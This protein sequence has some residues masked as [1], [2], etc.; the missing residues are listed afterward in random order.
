MIGNRDIELIQTN[1]WNSPHSKTNPKGYYVTPNYQNV[2]DK[3]YALEKRILDLISLIEIIYEWNQ[4]K[5]DYFISGQKMNNDGLFKYI[6]NNIIKAFPFNGYSR[7]IIEHISNPSLK[8]WAEEIFRMHD[9][10]VNWIPV[11]IEYPKLLTIDSEDLNKL[12]QIRF[13][14]FHLLSQLCHQIDSFQYEDYLRNQIVINSKGKFING[15][16]DGLV[17]GYKHG[18]SAFLGQYIIRKFPFKDITEFHS[19]GWE[20]G[21]EVYEHFTPMSFFRD[22]IWVKNLTKENSEAYVFHFEEKFSSPLPLENWLSI[23]WHLYRTIKIS[24]SENKRLDK[25]GYRMR[26]PYNAYVESEIEITLPDSLKTSWESIHSVNLLETLWDKNK[27]NPS[28]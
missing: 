23:L 12:M 9:R 14:R 4:K 27:L 15:N 22:L 21:K 16:L 11:K 13:D 2:A 26:R 1:W 18:L 7:E 25:K 3:K 17:Y 28:I 6:L 5:P 20:K 19:A 10:K 8:D 24:D